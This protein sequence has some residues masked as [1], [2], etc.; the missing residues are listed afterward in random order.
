M[1]K[2]LYI[3]ILVGAVSLTAWISASGEFD[4]GTPLEC[5][6]I[7]HDATPTNDVTS[8]APASTPEVTTEATKQHCNQ[9]RGNGDDSCSPGN[10]D[11]NHGP[12][13]LQKGRRK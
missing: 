6:P 7:T 12:N 1:T 10:S 3:L 8:E 2:L 11:R 9:G 13:D 4:R 5:I